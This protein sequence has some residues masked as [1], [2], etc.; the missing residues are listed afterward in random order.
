MD[1]FEANLSDLQP[2]QL[3]I[4][5]DKLAEV[6]RSM[7]TE[8]DSSIDPLPVTRL[9]PRTVLTDGHTRAFAAF[10]QGRRYVQVYWET[11]R[12]DWEAYEACVQWCLQERIHSVA[13]LHARIVTAEQYEELW[14]KRCRAMHGRLAAQRKRS[15]NGWD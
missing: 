6:A 10:V 12:L 11:D 14:Y 9:G 1:T 7:R 4:C 8:Q 3:Y 15:I 5:S 2:S 13:D